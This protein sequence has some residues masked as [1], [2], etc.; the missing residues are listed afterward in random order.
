MLCTFSSNCASSGVSSSFL[1]LLIDQS[2]CPIME[3]SNL[4]GLVIGRAVPFSAA[5][6]PRPATHQPMKGRL[7]DQVLTSVQSEAPRLD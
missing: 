1:P 3:G 6:A 7:V 5:L 2:F 4:I